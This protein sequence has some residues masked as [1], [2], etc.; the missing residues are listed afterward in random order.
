MG[1]SR[2][3][4]A[5]KP[6]NLILSGKEREV[7]GRDCSLTGSG[8]ALLFDIGKGMVISCIA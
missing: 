4:R 5:I 8:K 2:P 3:V 1:V 6:R 7:M